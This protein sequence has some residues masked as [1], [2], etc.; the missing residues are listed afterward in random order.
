MKYNPNKFNY[1]EL[2]KTTNADSTRFYVSPTGDK[3]PSVTTI[4]SHKKDMT[5]INNWRNRIGHSEAKFITQ[6]SAGAGTFMHKI[7]EHRI[8]N[9]EEPKGTKPVHDIGREM[10]AC[11][12]DKGLVKIDEIWGLEIPLYYPGLYAGTTDLA[13]VHEC[14]ESIIDFKNARRPKKEEWI[15]DYFYQG[16]AYGIAHNEVY[17]SNIKRVVIMMTFLEPEYRG[18]YQ[19]FII[20]GLE[21]DKYLDGW[22]RKVEEY[23][24]L[25][26]I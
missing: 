13:G 25:N 19:E 2:N 4:L 18:Q 8:L 10:A 12:I 1:V 21:F 5:M 16:V 14:K 22:L 26:S 9:K 15:I 17:G 24:K 3:L 20:E 23:Y 11:I 6:K 7:L